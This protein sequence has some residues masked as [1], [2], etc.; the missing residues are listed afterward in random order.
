MSCSSSSFSEGSCARPCPGPLH[1][2]RAL[3]PKDAKER[4]SALTLLQ[5]STSG[6]GS[7]KVSGRNRVP[8]PGTARTGQPRHPASDKIGETDLRRELEPSYCVFRCTCRWFRNLDLLLALSVSRREGRQRLPV[9]ASERDFPENIRPYR[10]V[11]EGERAWMLMQDT[12]C[13]N[14][15]RSLATACERES[16]L[17]W[18]RRCAETNTSARDDGHAFT[19]SGDSRQGHLFA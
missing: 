19:N 14:Q 9:S 3:P 6:L 8:K 13:V 18:S 1:R 11:T 5:N 7:V 4:A 10:L 2:V 16:I 12:D 15:N 17:E